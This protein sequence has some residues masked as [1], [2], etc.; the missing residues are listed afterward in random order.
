M[1]NLLDIA[2]IVGKAV[3]KYDGKKMYVST[4]ALNEDIIDINKC[5]YFNYNEKPSRANLQ[6]SEGD[7]IF[8]KMQGTKKTLIIET[9]N[10][11]NIYSTGFCAIKAK[12]NKISTKCLYYLLSSEIFLD[13]KD[14]YC[15]GATQK[16]ITNEGLS[17]IYIKLP[18]IKDQEI[19]CNYLDRIIDL[20][21]KFRKQ[22]F[23]LDNLIKSRF[24]EMFGDVVKNTKNWKTKKLNEICGFN[25][26][27]VEIDSINNKVWL[28]NL[29]M[30]ESDSGKIIDYYMIDEKEVPLS[31]ISFNE[32]YVLYS[33]L[34][35]YL[36]KVVIPIKSGYA[37]SELIAIETN[38]L[39]N[40]YFLA[41]A[42]RSKSFVDMMNLTSYGAKM[43][44]ASVDDLKNFNI[45]LPDIEM[46]KQFATF[47][48]QVDKLKSDA[49]KS[50]D[51]TQM[52]FD[53][54]MQEYF[55]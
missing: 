26:N 27:K 49:Q 50:L 3:D 28:L 4:G 11:Q 51:K 39:I 35:P 44:R 14:K 2:D 42:L 54:L 48:Q 10:S 20:N 29:D 24:V 17:K 40:K 52:L 25:N 46:Q 7:I 43:P 41:F 45:P 16:A 18:Q 31:T 8:A 47:V 9:D 32:K 21:R 53:S 38:S 15:S 13:N 30:I 1:I 12:N 33:K 6:V 36:N 37:T 22:I 55:G 19:I 23:L 5:E 34:R